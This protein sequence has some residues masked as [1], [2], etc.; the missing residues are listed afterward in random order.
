MK[1]LLLLASL[2]LI[3]AIQWWLERKESKRD[4]YDPKIPLT[5]DA[6]TRQRECQQFEDA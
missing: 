5:L 1:P 4:Q 6:L 3:I 2:A